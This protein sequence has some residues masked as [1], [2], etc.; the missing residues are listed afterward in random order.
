MRFTF[1]L[2]DLV[3]QIAFLSVVGLISPAEE[4]NTAKR[5]SKRELFL[6]Q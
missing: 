5:Q 3:K 4:V 1:E 6:P 2:V